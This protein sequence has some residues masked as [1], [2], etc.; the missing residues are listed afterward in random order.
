MHILL[1]LLIAFVIV[2]LLTRSRRETRACRWREDR[3]GNRGSLRKYQC[4]ACGAEVYTAK[5]GPPDTCRDPG[6]RS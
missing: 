3:S 4:M 1:G 6:R 5:D 2:V